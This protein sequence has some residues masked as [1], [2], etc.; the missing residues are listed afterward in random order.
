MSPFFKFHIYIYVGSVYKG[1][2]LNNGQITSEQKTDRSIFWTSR[3]NRFL[4]RYSGFILPLLGSTS[5]FLF[6]FQIGFYRLFRENLWRFLLRN[7]RNRARRTGGEDEISSIRFDSLQISYNIDIDLFTTYCYLDS[8]TFAH[9]LLLL[10]ILILEF[11][12]IFK[13]QTRFMYILKTK[14]FFGHF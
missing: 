3:T 6:Y 14:L 8:D 1:I 13:T 11:S 10:L 12:T 4:Q 9:F 7:E 5:I 2:L